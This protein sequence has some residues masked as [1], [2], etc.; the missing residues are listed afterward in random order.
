MSFLFI[1]IPNNH[2]VLLLLLTGQYIA[3]NPQCQQLIYSYYRLNLKG[4]GINKLKS[5]DR[6]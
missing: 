5:M 2:L 4:P 3:K 1:V 6:L